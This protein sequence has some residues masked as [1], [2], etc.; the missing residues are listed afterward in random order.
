MI[1]KGAVK[2]QYIPIFQHVADIS[3]KPLA[4]R[5]F[6]AFIDKIGLVQNSFLAKREC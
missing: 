3:T 1:Q 5:K 2:I 6:E 4:K